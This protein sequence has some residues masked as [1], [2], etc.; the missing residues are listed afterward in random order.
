MTD[1][2]DADPDM[3][4]ALEIAALQDAEF[5]KTG[6]LVGPLHGVVMSIKDQYDTFDMRTTSGADAFY[7][8]DRP[9][10]DA[11]FIKRLR[12][13]GAI[14]LAKSNLGE[15]ASGIPRSSF[16]GTFC[17]PYD[18]ERSPS[19]SSSGSG[20]SVAANLVTCAIAE[21]TGSSIR[22]PARANNAVG[23]APTQE[24]V[25]RD[26]MIG[27]GIHT[28]VG[29]IC[30]TVE[31]V[32]KIMDVIAGYDP[33]DELTV[34]SVGPHARAALRELRESRPPRRTQDRRDARIHGQ[35]AVH[36]HG[37]GDHR[38]RGSRGRRPAQ[39]RCRHRRSG[40]GRRAVHRPASASTT[41]RCTTSCSR[42]QFPKLFPVSAKGEPQGDHLAKLL[43]M[44][45]DP[46]QVP[47]ELTFR[48]FG[49]AQA[50]GEGRFMMNKYLRERGDAAIRTN[51]DLVQK[52]QFHQDPQFPDRKASRA[53]AEK[54]VE[55]DMADRM[56]RRFAIQQM[57]LQCMQEQG[58]D[59]IVYP[60]SN[61]PPAKLGAP[62]EP[63]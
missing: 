14:I 36:R 24:L 33:K 2:V 37:R 59:A 19:G 43:D 3:P 32:A 22:G 54:A 53:N 7:A 6:K 26:G 41:R 25:S 62:P 29:P 57:V 27:A 21:E 39:A 61:L 58:I 47:A 52:A 44:S 18:T 8:N 28:R 15:Y 60:S 38:H 55:L 50:V 31:D 42:R 5:A 4:D 1:K 40:R 45:F 20:S 16:G 17:N 30:R 9:P 34:F 35:G 56:L 23:L 12:A 46:A 11:T 49:A 10:D 13:A 63:P 48:D 51:A